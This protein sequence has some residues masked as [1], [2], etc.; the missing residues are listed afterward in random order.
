M[1]GRFVYTRNFFPHFP[2]VKY[3]KYSDVGDILRCIRRDYASGVLNDVQSELVAPRRPIEYLYDLQED[4]WE[5]H[6][7]AEDPGCA[8]V[9]MRL[10]EAMRQNAVACGDVMFLPESQM[11]SRAGGSTPYELRFDETYNP[12]EDL[13]ETASMVGDPDRIEDQ[14]SLL[15]HGD[16]AV[17]YWA[18]AGLYASRD[19]IASHMERLLPHLDD[20]SACVQIEL[21]AA[22]YHA[23]K[24]RRAKAI[25]E[26]HIASENDYLAHQA[27][28]KILYMP[29]VAGDFAGSIGGLPAEPDEGDLKTSV[30][31]ASF[32]KWQALSMY[33]YLYMGESL[34]YPDDLPYIDPETRIRDW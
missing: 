25:L 30:N 19:H 11:I 32:P 22:C 33:R 3:Q 5:I 26:S 6:N 7:L 21:A 16:E 27:V 23:Y 2:V 17:R 12:L 20:P 15:D 10:R 13:F 9:L 4:P 28:A 24:D 14:I 1:D 18:A 31:A 29:A 34:Y 8:D